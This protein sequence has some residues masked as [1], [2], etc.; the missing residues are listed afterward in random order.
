[1]KKIIFFFLLLISFSI[2]AQYED[3]QRRRALERR[4]VNRQ[5]AE[6]VKFKTKKYLGIVVYDANKIAKKTKVKIK[7]E[8]GKKL[9]IAI[10]KFN[11]S[12]KEMIR[13]NSFTFL[14]MEKYAERSQNEAQ[15]TGDFSIMQKVQKTLNKRFKPFSDD[16]KEKEKN[17]D[18]SLKELFSDKEF[19]KWIKYKKKAKRN[20]K[21]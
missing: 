9:K 18:T 8:K 10:S 17:L 4:Q 1:M 16:L 12:L 20:A 3:S 5:P 11:K 14:E 19:K 15:K 13:L 6:K 2:N 7:S 21:E